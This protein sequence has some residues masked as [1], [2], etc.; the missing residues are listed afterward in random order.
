MSLLCQTPRLQEGDSG[1]IPRTMMH[2]KNTLSVIC[3]SFLIQDIRHA[4][5]IASGVSAVCFSLADPICVGGP[6]PSD[7]ITVSA[8]V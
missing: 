6:Q 2:T 1:H 3:D 4:G 8:R 7:V 5:N